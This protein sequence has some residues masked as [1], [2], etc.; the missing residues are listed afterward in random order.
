MEDWAER[1]VGEMIVSGIRA[2]PFRPLVRKEVLNQIRAAAAGEDTIL[3]SPG[4][5]GAGMVP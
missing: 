2:G 4:Y 1:A 3:Q 5:A